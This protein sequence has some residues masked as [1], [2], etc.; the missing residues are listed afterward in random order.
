MIVRGGAIGN[1]YK[2]FQHCTEKFDQLL[3]SLCGGVWVHASAAAR[4]TVPSTTDEV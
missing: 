3:R 1:R 2:N 4:S